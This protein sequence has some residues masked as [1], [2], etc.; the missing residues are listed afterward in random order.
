MPYVSPY[1]KDY[2]ELLEILAQSEC[3]IDKAIKHTGRTVYLLRYSPLPKRYK[4]LREFH[5]ALLASKGKFRH[6]GMDYGMKA[7]P[8]NDW[9]EFTGTFFTKDY[10]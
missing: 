3:T 9:I 6:G 8:I 4:E 7:S 1:K 5:G 2:Q 10:R